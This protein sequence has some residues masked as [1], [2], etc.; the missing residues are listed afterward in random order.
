MNTIPAKCVIIPDF[1]P[2]DV[3]Q[4][5]CDYTWKHEASFFERS[6]SLGFPL[7]KS[8]A[9]SHGFDGWKSHIVEMLGLRLPSVLDA[10]GLACFN[11]GKIEA[12]VSAILDKGFLEL[13]NDTFCAPDRLLTYVYYFH[14]VPKRFKGGQLII[15]GLEP[16]E[17]V[18][19]PEN[20][21]CIFFPAHCYHQ[22]LPVACRDF[23]DGRFSVNG[24]ISP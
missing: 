2:L 16:Q 14:S 21:T 7:Q 8:F 12:D 9:A 22:V 15:H 17:S 24:W 10:F 13:H 20:N 1:F 18:V 5:L 3:N 19:E 4:S 23:V 11:P 6:H